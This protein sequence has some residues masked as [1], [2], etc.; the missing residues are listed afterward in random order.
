MD[1]GAYH[2]ALHFDTLSETRTRGP[3]PYR[4]TACL[5]PRSRSSVLA[6]ASKR[7]GA[8]DADRPRHR[9][10][11]GP[12]ARARR[13]RRRSRQRDPLGARLGAARPD[14]VAR[15][16]RAPAHDRARR[17]RA[18]TAAARVRAPPR[19]PRP[20]RARVRDRL[21][22]GGAA[23]RA[24]RR[25]GPARLPG[26][27]GPVRGAVHRA[28]E[29]GRSSQARERGARPRSTRRSRC[30]SG[31][32]TPCST[33]AACRRCWRSSATTLGCALALVDEAG[34]VVGE[35]HGARLA[36]SSDVLELPVVADGETLVAPGREAARRALGV[37][38][39]RAAPR[40]VGARV[41]ALAPARGLGGRAPARRRPARGSRARP[42]RRARDLAPDRRLRA[43][44]AAALR[45]AARGRRRHGAGGDVRAAVA[46]VL[47]VAGRP[48]PL[49]V[50]PRP[51]RVPRS[52]PTSRRRRSSSRGSSS[53][54]APGTRVGVGRPASGAG[55]G[56]SLLEARAAL[57]AVA[58]AVASYRDLGSLELLLAFPAPPSRRSSTASSARPRTNTWLLE[59]LRC[60]ARLRL[61]LE[62]GG[63]PARR[64][65]AHAPLPDGAAPRA[66]RQA[67]RRSGAADGAVAGR[68]GG[69]GARRAREARRLH[70]SGDESVGNRT[71]RCP[72]RFATIWPCPDRADRRRPPQLPFVS[73][74]AILRS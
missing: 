59:S 69:A 1:R 32:R 58:G 12:R 57:D 41:R 17:R 50:A 15:G 10:P 19:R 14:A 20:R 3:Y 23:G 68:Q 51:R 8:D 24:R 74:R 54:L 29:G 53:Q 2:A 70:P 44:P 5:L 64:A 35:R 49:G 66:D 61:P 67:S 22:L 11:A 7:R 72:V 56:R 25:G 55:L 60:A 21:R 27:R 40:P 38:P 4:G 30:T 13:G 42:A 73:A 6:I 65:P 71:P 31:S 18:R 43:R 52:R 48:L 33:A 28:D 37:R 62:R 63:R 36:A 47:D 39:A 45:G 46:R 26:R 34:R 16:R 9:R